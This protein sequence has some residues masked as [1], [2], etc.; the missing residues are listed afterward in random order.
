MS[1]IALSVLV[2]LSTCQMGQSSRPA[3]QPALRPG[4][5]AA[6]AKGKFTFALNIDNQALRVGELWS[7][8]NPSGK[9]IPKEQL[10]FRLHKDV[11]LFRL[12]EDVTGFVAAD[13]KK[14]FSPTADLGV[15]SKNS[16]GAYFWDFDSDTATMDRVL[17]VPTENSLLYIEDSGDLE[18]SSNIKFQRSN[19]KLDGRQFIVLFFAPTKANERFQ[20]TISGLP[21]HKTW[22]R[23][24]A[25]LLCLA[26]L[27]WMLWALKA[28]QL[29]AGG[30]Q[31]GAL[32]AQARRDQIVKAI[33][34]LDR[35]FEAEKIKEKRYERRHRELMDELAAVL[36][37][38][39][40]SGKGH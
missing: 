12:D 15:G 33:E 14:S 26:V 13:D 20:V 21:S 23:T 38:I 4:G 28:P 5:T 36:R 39:E 27:G 8:E 9:L 10:V 18:F 40:L 2:G 35:D 32:S 34:I 3:S 1:A 11:R 7:I 6:D 30:P 31:L 16:S 19:R 29:A 22:P 17:P 25:A 24:A 37:E